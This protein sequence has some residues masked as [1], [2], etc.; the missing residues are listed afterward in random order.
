MTVFTI[1]STLTT[2][3]K[4]GP[5]SSTKKEPTMLAAHPIKEIYGMDLKKS[6]KHCLTP[7]SKFSSQP[8]LHRSKSIRAQDRRQ[9]SATTPIG[10]THYPAPAPAIR[11]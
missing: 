1:A 6:P 11:I 5:Y 8:R 4:L 10:K 9:L 2:V 7:I 3:E